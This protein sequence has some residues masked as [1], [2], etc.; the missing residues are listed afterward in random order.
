MEDGIDF[1]SNDTLSLG[2]SGTFRVEALLEFERHPYLAPGSCSS[3]LAD[4]IYKYLQMAEEDTANFHGA[5]AGVMVG[6]GGEGNVAIF[7]GYAAPWRR[8]DELGHAS[9]YDGMLQSLVWDKR[10]FR[11]TIRTRSERS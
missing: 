7:A 9:A 1:V 11:T 3:R 6:S 4:G 8:D 10:P 2:S 5:E